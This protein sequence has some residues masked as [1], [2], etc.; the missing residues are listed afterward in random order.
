MSLLEQFVFRTRFLKK[1]KVV[2]DI[3]DNEILKFS[4]VSCGRYIPK[5]N[6]VVQ[7]LNK[8]LWEIQNA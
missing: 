1:A 8:D 7:I 3:V 6:I 4:I 2:S 5:T